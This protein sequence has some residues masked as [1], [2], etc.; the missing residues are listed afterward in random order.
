MGHLDEGLIQ[1]FL[2]K[3]TTGTES[4]RVRGHLATCAACQDQV[5]AHENRLER[6]GEALALLDSDPDLAVARSRALAWAASRGEGNNS[7]AL[8][9]GRETP[10]G[11]TR[12]PSNA[13]M[14]SKRFWKS[15]SLARAAS[16]ALFITGAAVT[17][18]PGSPVH[19]WIMDGWRSISGTTDTG[20]HQ[21]EV[22]GDPSGAAQ[23]DLPSRLQETGAS[24]LPGEDGVEIWIQG[25]SA[26]AGLTVLW[27]DGD[28]VRVFSGEGTSYR[29]AAGRLEA[30]SPT[31]PVRIEIPRAV[32]DLTLGANGTTLLRKVG[33]SLEVVAPTLSQTAQE[34]RFAPVTGGSGGGA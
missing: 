16:I 18:L 14:P 27:T 23:E 26:A 15:P 31:G 29:T 7:A 20:T 6:T 34:I 2:D 24:I 25:L 33:G 8:S 17:A 4:D 28:Q 5:R 1:A 19:R 22:E 9:M 13:W 30:S 21:A 3:E 12:H 11:P 32:R 10:E